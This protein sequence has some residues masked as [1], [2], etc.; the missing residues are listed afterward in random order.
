MHTVH[1]RR[2]VEDF[3]EFVAKHDFAFTRAIAF[4]AL[5]EL[6]RKHILKDSRFD[7]SRPSGG[8]DVLKAIIDSPVGFKAV[9]DHGVKLAKI[10]LAQWRPWEIHAV[11]PKLK[12]E[13]PKLHMGCKYL[14]GHHCRQMHLHA[15]ARGSGAEWAEDDW[16]LLVG[17]LL[18]GTGEAA[19]DYGVESWTD[20]VKHLGWLNAALRRVGGDDVTPWSTG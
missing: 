17:E 15:I 7:T 20:A 4:K 14:R 8:F 16:D 3:C 11:L 18:P 1:R 5:A 10:P 6:Q 9:A 13:L 12:D 19:L 2:V